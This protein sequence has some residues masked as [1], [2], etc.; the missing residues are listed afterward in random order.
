VLQEIL[1]GNVEFRARG[2]SIISPQPW[3]NQSLLVVAHRSEEDAPI[4]IRIVATPRTGPANTPFYIDLARSFELRVA[5]PSNAG[6]FH[7]DIHFV[8]PLDPANPTH[9]ISR[10]IYPNGKRSYKV[11]LYEATNTLAPFANLLGESVAVFIE[12]RDVIGMERKIV[13]VGFGF[14]TIFKW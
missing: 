1:A 9:D 13:Q 8:S 2:P 11:T 7:D 10:I 5:Q 14:E 6:N 12:T 3:T 4:W